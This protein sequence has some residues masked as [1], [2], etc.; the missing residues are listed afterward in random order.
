MSVLAYSPGKAQDCLWH[1]LEAET[2]LKLE[3]ASC[4]AEIF[5]TQS[6]S[7]SAI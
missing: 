1:E 4:L 2:L 5:Y 6:K 7:I 3:A